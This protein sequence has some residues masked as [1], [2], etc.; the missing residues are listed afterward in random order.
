MF[1]QAFNQAAKRPLQKAALSLN[2]WGCSADGMTLAGFFVGLLCVPLLAMGHPLWAL[3]AMALNRLAD[4]LDGALARLNTPSDRGAY[5]DIA[6]DFLFYA[7]VPFGFALANPAENA[8]PAA[9]LLFAFMGTACSFLAFAV[10]AAKRGMTS[11]A[12]PQ[13]GFYYLGG[14]TESTETMAVFALMCLKPMWFAPLAWGFAAL[15]ALTTAT[16]M[17]AG[18]KAFGLTG[19]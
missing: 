11:L 16:R 18:W 5:L 8:L 6:C 10:L 3:A 15:C 12:Y 14:L 7:S 17:V 9:A 1:D 2:G 19:R 13:K 4:G